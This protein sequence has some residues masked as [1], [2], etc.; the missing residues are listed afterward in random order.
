MARASRI[1]RHLILTGLLCFSAQG[2]CAPPIDAQTIR[3]PATPRRG[4]SAIAGDSSTASAISAGAPVVIGLDTLFVLYGNLGPFSPVDRAAAVV[5]RIRSNEAAIALG[6]S[7][8]VTDFESSSEVSLGDVVIMTVLNADAAPLGAARTDLARRYAE[9]IRQRV[10]VNVERTSTKAILIDAGL[11][12]AATVVLVLLL[13]LLSWG[14]PRLYVRIEALR[15]VRLPA[16]RIQ[17]FELLSAGRLSALLVGISRVARIV[18]TLLLFYVYVPLVLSFFPWTAPL[19]RRIV[20]YA[21]RPFIAAW[22]G[23]VVYLPNLFYLAAGIII[24]RYL[25]KFL[26]LLSEAVR[27]GSI[28]FNGFYPDWAIPTYK[29]VRILVFAF[30]ATV[31]YPYLP[32]ASSDAFKG[33]SIFLGILFSLGSSA[34]IG[35]MVAGV[36]LTYTRAFQIGDRVKINDTVGDVV[37]KTLIVT[38]LRTIKNVAVTIPNGAVLS[39]QVVNYTTLAA[40]NGL[41]LNTSIT[42]GYDVPWRTVHELMIRAAQRTESIA[43]EPTPFVLQTSLDD[44][45]VSYELNAF[46]CRADIMALT[47][48]QLHQNIQ[49]MFNESTRDSRRLNYLSTSSAMSEFVRA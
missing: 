24:V 17:Q 34:A 3:A 19:S 33:V 16:V 37:E 43:V 38:R 7:L 44:F 28:T 9:V 14:F 48:S 12:V 26:G 32:G 11:A 29:I 25:L 10:L 22:A 18:L 42:I 30:A 47:Y 8:V 13:R 49:E 2:I 5:K 1:T 40:S 4:E 36:V 27:S 6:D 20:S 23:L 21:L 31:L 15:R 35:N 41:I 45:Y 46:T 39:S